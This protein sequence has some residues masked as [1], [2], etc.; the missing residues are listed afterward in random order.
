MSSSILNCKLKAEEEMQTEMMTGEVCAD[1]S[2][3]KE[4]EPHVNET[5]PDVKQWQVA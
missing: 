5:D 3:S 2:C 4:V 1:A